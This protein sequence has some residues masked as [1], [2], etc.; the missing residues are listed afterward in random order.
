MKIILLIFCCSMSVSL[1]AQNYFRYERPIVK[2][3]YSERL[4]DT[5]NY[6]IL[7]PKTLPFSSSIKYP[8]IVVFDRQNRIGYTHTLN[9]IDYLTANSSLPDAII[10]GISLEGKQRSLWTQPNHNKNGKADDFI[11]FILTDLKNANQTLPMNDFMLLIGHSRTAIFASYALSKEPKRINAIFGASLSYFDFEDEKQKVL[12]EASLTQIKNSKRNT[13]YYFSVGGKQNRDAHEEGVLKLRDYLQKASLPENFHWKFYH[14][15]KA[16]HHT[17]YGLTVGE[18]LYDLFSPYREVRNESFSLLK[19]PENA[20][21]VP[22]EGFKKIFEE[23]STQLGYPLVPDYVFYNS[24]ASYFGYAKNV[25]EENK[26]KLQFKVLQKAIQDYAY[27]QSFQS[28][29][30]ELYLQRG[31]NKQALEYYTRALELIEKDN[32]LSDD[33]K[34]TTST[35]TREQIQRI[36]NGL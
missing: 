27:A 17:S 10:I 29:I 13:Y 2:S 32:I 33:E 3:L 12:F 5:V 7:L 1:L 26:A 25:K 20:E 34:K 14:V 31:A 23:K 28:W 15:N 18:A 36:K 22:W 11:D 6:E 21:E 24:I 8:L 9:T 16:D 35:S 19:L 30:G 4:A